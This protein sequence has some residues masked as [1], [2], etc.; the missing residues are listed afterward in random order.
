MNDES[1]Y[2]GIP[3]YLKNYKK[4]TFDKYY[5][6]YEEYLSPTSNKPV[7]YQIVVPLE[8]FECSS[9][10][11]AIKL[12]SNVRIV[13]GNGTFYP[14]I[15]EENKD[16]WMNELFPKIE[17]YDPPE[18]FL[19]IDY[20]MKKERVPSE[21]KEHIENDIIE[22]IREVFRILRLYK[23]GFLRSGFIYLFPKAPCDPPHD[24]DDIISYHGN[25]YSPNKYSITKNDVIKLQNLFKKYLK[26]SNHKD[27][28][29]SAIYYLD[30]GLKRTEPTDSLVDFTTALECLLAKGKMEIAFTLRVYTAAFLK[31]NKQDGRKIYDDIKETYNL[32]SIIVHGKEKDK[33]VKAGEFEYREYSKKTE[34]YARKAII[35]WLDMID[36]GKTAEEIYESIENKLLS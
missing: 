19:E 24:Y 27:F 12:S 15:I 13:S 10:L 30:K 32:R 1:K 9:N 33:K 11:S 26:N 2:A 22:R 14:D 20:E 3:S 17:Y 35:K 8:N 36:K 5:T 16:R 29:H 6:E 31:G 4:Q 28:P 21:C 18:F 23:D 7:K 34:R 25:S